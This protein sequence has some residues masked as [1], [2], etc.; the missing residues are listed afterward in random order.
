METGYEEFNIVVILL[1]IFSNL[2]CNFIIG[3]RIIICIPQMLAYY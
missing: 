1:Y 3:F 2:I